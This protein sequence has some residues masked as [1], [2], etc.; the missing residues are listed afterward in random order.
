MEC[1]WNV[2]GMWMECGWKADRMWMECRWN[3]DRMQI[4]CGWNVDG[5]WSSTI[6]AHVMILLLEDNLAACCVLMSSINTVGTAQELVARVIIVCIV[7]VLF[8]F[9]R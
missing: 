1:R 5:M 6:I 7:F 9:C 8:N 3:V 2:D 4:E